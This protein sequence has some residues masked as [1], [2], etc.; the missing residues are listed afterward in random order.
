MD[1]PDYEWK[2]DA[3]ETSSRHSSLFHSSEVPYRNG[4]HVVVYAKDFLF[5]NV[6][7]EWDQYMRSKLPSYLVPEGDEDMIRYLPP[8]QRPITLMAYIGSTHTRTPM[9]VD[10]LNTVAYNIHVVGGGVK[11]WWMVHAKDKGKLERLIQEQTGGEGHLHGDNVWVDPA[12][13]VERERERG[14]ESHRK[15]RQAKERRTKTES[16]FI[17]PES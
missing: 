8:K 9:H 6:L 13:Y 14:R 10:R 11:K 12:M 3:V 15:I 17:L 16:N 2:N 7:P 1:D 4:D 5:Q